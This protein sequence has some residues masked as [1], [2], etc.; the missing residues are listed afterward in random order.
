ME[1]CIIINRVAPIEEVFALTESIYEEK[2]KNKANV[3]LKGG[4][5]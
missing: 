3:Q 1:L 5:A 4:C 2:D